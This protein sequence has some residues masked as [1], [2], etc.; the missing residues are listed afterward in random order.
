MRSGA[1]QLEVE[2]EK[3]DPTIDMRFKADGGAYCRHR[4]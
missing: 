3:M 4:S 1:V 2:R